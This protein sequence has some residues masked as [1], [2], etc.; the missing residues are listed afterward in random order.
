MAGTKNQTTLQKRKRGGK[1]NQ[2]WSGVEELSGS[3]TRKFP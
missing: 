3:K 1:R 2:W